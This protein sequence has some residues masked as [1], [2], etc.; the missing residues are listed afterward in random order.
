ML[1]RTNKV[2][3]RFLTVVPAAFVLYS[4]AAMAANSVGDPLEQTRALLAGKPAAVST[5]SSAR[6]GAAD[7]RSR[8]DAQESARSL[9]LGATTRP[10][11]RRE[12]SVSTARGKEVHENAQ[13]QARD[14]LLSRHEALAGSR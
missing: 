3:A 4:G 11:S 7:T 5:P 14:L 6:R 1:S 10:P 12:A 13:E 2:F 8:G 9:L